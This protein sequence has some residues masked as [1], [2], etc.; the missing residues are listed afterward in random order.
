[1]VVRA[2]RLLLL[3]L[4]LRPFG[5]LALAFGMHRFPKLLAFDPLP[6][7]QALLNPFVALGILMLIL[8][9][10]T[11]LALLSVADLSFVLPMT[12]AGYI[13][14]VLLGKFFLGEQVDSTRWLGTFLVFAGVAL[15]SSTSA[16]SAPNTK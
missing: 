6:Y 9:V 10:F 3:T 8:A 2:Y 4:L 7:L 14:S 13:V 15:V 1:V 12:A 11:R 16:R 5:N